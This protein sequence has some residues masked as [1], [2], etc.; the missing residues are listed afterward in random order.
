MQWEKKQMA[1]T[2]KRLG[3]HVSAETNKH[4]TIEEQLKVNV[5]QTSNYIVTAKRGIVPNRTLFF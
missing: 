2:E 4:A 5:S 3:K 1:N